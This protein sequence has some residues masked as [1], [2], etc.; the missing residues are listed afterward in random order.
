MKKLN[1]LFSIDYILIFIGS[2]LFFSSEFFSN[3]F[4]PNSISYYF[5]YFS[6][7]N[8]S[9]LV[10]T[11]FRPVLILVLYFGGLILSSYLHHRLKSMPGTVLHK[12]YLI[13]T[14][15]LHSVVL[16]WLIFAGMIVY[17]VPLKGDSFIV[18]IFQL[19]LIAVFWLITLVIGV[20][21][22]TVIR[23]SSIN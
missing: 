19:P 23:R 6:G 15:I 18:L 4:F 12:I 7:L 21:T 10:M 9:Q 20:S 5:N 13:F 1:T 3:E 11:L 14:S 17:D 2:L 22:F 8:F 16:I